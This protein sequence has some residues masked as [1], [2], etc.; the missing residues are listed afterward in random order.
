MGTMGKKKMDVNF[1][2]YMYGTTGRSVEICHG[3]K[4]SD[5]WS[6]HTAET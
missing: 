3:K 1:V 5:L 4:V 6:P 2:H